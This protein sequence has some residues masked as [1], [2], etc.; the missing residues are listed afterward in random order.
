MNVQVEELSYQ[1]QDKRIIE[2][3]GLQVKQ[4]EFIGLIGPNGSGKSTLLKAIYRVLEPQAGRIIWDGKDLFHLSHKET[5]KRMAVVS[6]ETSVTF[7]FTV[8]DIVS[9]GRTP[10]KSIFESD[11]KKDKEI[12]EESLDKVGMSHYADRSFTTLSGGEKQRVLI[13]RALAQ[14]AQFLILDE[15]TNHLDIRYQLQIM[16]LVKRLRITTLAALHDLNIASFYCD[17]IYVL[18]AGRVVASGS[19]ELIL[20]P[21]LLQ[22]VFGVTAEIAIHHITGKPH[23]I[24]LPEMAIF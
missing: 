24:F 3:I 17:R 19:P 1:I 8:K 15:P 14:Q 5:A 20:I 18:K 11:T 6:Q 10:H 21:E 23:I 13:A 7:D 12:V 2:A 16:D 9:M 4:G 22:D